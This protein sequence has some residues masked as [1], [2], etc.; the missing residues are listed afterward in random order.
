MST[1]LSISSLGVGNSGGVEV[2]ESQELSDLVEGGGGGGGG[3]PILASAEQ[4]TYTVW[5]GTKKHKAQ[6]DV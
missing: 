2:G 3:G 4:T 1:A 5:G 6:L